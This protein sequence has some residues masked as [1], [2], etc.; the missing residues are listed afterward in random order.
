M[1]YLDGAI[2]S[3]TISNI[4]REGH[5]CLVMTIFIVRLISHCKMSPKAASKSQS[6][7][8]IILKFMLQE[9]LKGI[10]NRANICSNWRFVN[11]RVKELFYIP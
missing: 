6:I 8:P 9:I 1:I 7:M 3:I 5:E 10:L 2:L 4:N 11:N